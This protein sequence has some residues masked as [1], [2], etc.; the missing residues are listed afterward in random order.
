MWW[1][2][3][4]GKNTPHNGDNEIYVYTLESRQTNGVPRQFPVSAAVVN[5][6]LLLYENI[7]NYLIK[8]YKN[9]L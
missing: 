2:G 8:N 7:L 6:M 3:A 5:A 1:N 9:L 4:F